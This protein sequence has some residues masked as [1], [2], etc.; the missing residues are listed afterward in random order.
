MLYREPFAAS[1]TAALQYG[2]AAARA[3]PLAEAVH[4]FSA[5]IVGLKRALH[6]KW[7]LVGKRSE[8]IT[9]VGVYRIAAL[10]VNPKGLRSARGP[11]K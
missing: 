8:S 5:A 6:L 4:L 1:F 3:H 10:P 7:P 9:S 2:A 11:K